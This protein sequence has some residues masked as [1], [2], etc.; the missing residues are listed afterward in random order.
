M[1]ASKRKKRKKT[2]WLIL[3]GIAVI[4]I[5]VRLWLPSYL[6]KKVNFA[7]A[8]G[9]THYQGAA[10]DI[11][12]S[13]LQ[14]S[15]T[16]R[17]VKLEKRDNPIPVPFFEA[18]AVTVGLEWPTLW[19]GKLT[20][21]IKVKKPI[22]NFVNGPS[23]QASQTFAEHGWGEVVERLAPFA[24]NRFAVDEGE[25][26]Y[27]DF[28]S[29][30]KVNLQLTNLSLVASNL[31]NA[32]GKETLLPSRVIGSASAYNGTAMID[33][34]VSMVSRS[35]QFELSAEL[36]EIQLAHLR[37]FLRAYSNADPQRGT[38]GL[39]AKAA[40]R[41]N[42]ITGF[43]QTQGRDTQM[44]TWNATAP[45]SSTPSI[46]AELASWDFHSADVT[47]TEFSGTLKPASSDRWSIVGETLLNIFLKGLQPVMQNTT[48]TPERDSLAGRD[49]GF[50]KS[51]QTERKKE[52]FIKRLFKKKSKRDTRK[53]NGEKG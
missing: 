1:E 18:Q 2:V 49:V 17:S 20:C 37:S 28:H 8:H 39:Y 15:Y 35:P 10:K 48:R 14:L 27:R 19:K 26:H 9:L 16:L 6:H 21:A 11:E 33:L 52:S 29:S 5:A 41:Q 47:R 42:E 50:T 44:I 51:D 24:I 45:A 38:F 36:T 12:V 53:K 7:L 30:P 32:D 31:V 46:K 3:T 25:I 40:T 22:L 43:V 4:L 34:S 13:I 23:E